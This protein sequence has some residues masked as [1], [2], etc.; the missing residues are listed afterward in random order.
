VNGSWSDDLLITPDLSSGFL[1]IVFDIAG[2]ALAGGYGGV[3]YSS[4]PT[5]TPTPTPTPISNICFPAGT[6][7]QTDQGILPIE[8]LDKTVHTIRGLPIL[9]VTRTVTLDKYL[10]AFAPHSIGRHIPTARTIMTKDHQIE[11]EGRLAP[12]ER[13][14]DYSREIKKVKYNG[15]VLYNVLLPTHSRMNVN[16]LVCETLHPENII[17]KLYTKRY[18][19]AERNA[20]IGELNTSLH[21]K[22]FKQYKKVVNY[23]TSPN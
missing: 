2:H 8:K 18:S 7:I 23:L 6:P 14:L 15:E 17:A 22:N 19:E 20:M 11:F 9:H 16:G 12:A 10:I 4:D 21:N 1:S 5:P 13:F 3:W